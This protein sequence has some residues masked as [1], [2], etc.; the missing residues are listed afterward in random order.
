MGRTQKAE[1][2]ASKA[3]DKTVDGYIAGLEGWQAEIVSALRQLILDA[4]PDATE[5]IKWS[6]P[7][8]EDNGPFCHI[9]VFKNN[10]NFGFWRGAELPDPKRASCKARAPRCDT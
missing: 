10:V 5:S 1:R 6:Q 7:V 2:S 9:K 8:Y 4:A 3:T